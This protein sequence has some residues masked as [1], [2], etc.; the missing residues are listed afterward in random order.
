ML[1]SIIILYSIKFINCCLILRY[2][3]PS[4]RSMITSLEA[5]SKEIRSKISKDTRSAPISLTHDGWTSN[6]TQSYDTV[7]CHVV[8][9]K[10]ELKSA[11][12]QTKKVEGKHTDENIAAN[13]QATM[14]D[15]KLSPPTAITT[16]NAANEQKAIRMLGITRFGCFGH[17]INL[18]VKKALET[19]DI[20]SLLKKGRHLVSFFH[21]SSSATD[22][23]IAKQKLLVPSKI[24]HRLVMDCPTRWNSTLSMLSRLAEQMPIIV[25]VASDEKCAFQNWLQI[26]SKQTPTRLKRSAQHR[27][28]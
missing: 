17:R 18:V 24:S 15:W 28:F 25:N 26:Q 7:I 14:T 2:K 6:M 9:D 23:L 1:Y 16:D 27:M 5:T 19:P 20:S 8:T 21:K 12:L 13:L 22:L 3:I 11:V 10:W 4:K